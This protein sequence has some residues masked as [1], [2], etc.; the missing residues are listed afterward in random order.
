ML[1]PRLALPFAIVT[2]WLPL[3]A[4]AFAAA[5]AYFDIGGLLLW[6][7]GLVLGLVVFPIGI[8]ASKSLEAKGV[9]ALLSLTCL[10]AIALPIVNGRHEMQRMEDGVSI[11]ADAFGKYCV[12]D[13]RVVNAQPP[14]RAISLRVRNERESA[15]PRWIA[16]AP[17]LARRIR[18]DP[19]F[20][21][22]SGLV[23][24]VNQE[25]AKGEEAAYAVCARGSCSRR[26]STSPV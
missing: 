15:A 8:A 11:D 9:C 23:T 2:A 16:G 21:S 26:P 10:V 6:P 18:E 4:S 3:P 14:A 19:S 25:P 17:G 5:P 20:C 1:H 22:Q 13:R 24:V 7:L 12:N